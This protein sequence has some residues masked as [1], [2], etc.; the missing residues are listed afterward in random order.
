[1]DISNNSDAIRT[2]SSRNNIDLKYLVDGAN[3][4]ISKIH[5]NPENNYYTTLGLPRKASRVEIR[6]RWKMFMLLYHPD[7]QEETRNGLPRGEKS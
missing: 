3:F 2:F 5:F 1:M 7:R 6:E 4:V